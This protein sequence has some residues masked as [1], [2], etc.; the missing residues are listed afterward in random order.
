MQL[1]IDST[2]SYPASATLARTLIAALLAACAAAPSW[3][4]GIA[5][6]SPWQFQTNADRAA[7]S[8]A[9][10]MAQR[11]RGGF[12]DGY[13]VTNY[14]FNCSLNTTATGNAGNNGLSASTS[15]PVIT[16]SGSTSSATSANT[17]S[18]SLGYDTPGL[19]LNGTAGRGQLGSTQSNTGLLGS[20]VM[21]STTTAATGAVKAGA[22]QSSQV[23]NS[24]QS[25]LGGQQLASITGSSACSGMPN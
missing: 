10:D 2:R 15:S 7:K 4:N 24:D 21:G 23:L 12:Y 3:A 16:N 22:G 14:S 13:N 20:S 18:N 5:E 25:T 17:A 1:L 11:K 6:N 19:A 9:L 8:T